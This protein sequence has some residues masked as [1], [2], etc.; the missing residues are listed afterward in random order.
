MKALRIRAYSKINLGLKITGKRS[1]GY[2]DIDTILQSI[3][4]ADEVTV[5]SQAAGK[6]T[7]TMEPDLDISMEE[8]LAFRAARLLRERVGF[9]EG[10]QIRLSK[11]IPVGAGLGGASSDA[12]AVLAGLNHIFQLGLSKEEFKALGVEL[13]SDVPF[14]FEGGRCRATG[15][16]EILEKLPEDQTLEAVV[17]LVPPFSLHT[18]EVYQAFDRH[19]PRALHSPYPNDLEAA[20]L[21][22][23]PQLRAYREFLV[24]MGVPFGLSGSGPTYYALFE[25]VSMARSFAQT[26]ESTLGGQTSL[27]TQ[28][29]LGYEFPSS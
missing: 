2:H 26:A 22:L 11:T 18:R 17:L 13:G 27:C 1:D 19:T 3:D 9:K 7:L 5:E 23:R 10:V 4:L 12:A 24:Q 29:S 8:N 16:G 20:A 6:V 14:F 21:E 28:T 25:S 15:R